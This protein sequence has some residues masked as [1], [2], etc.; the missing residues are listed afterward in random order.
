M[1]QSQCQNPNV[2]SE[3]RTNFDV[4]VRISDTSEVRQED[5]SEHY[6]E[7]VAAMKAGDA[8][9]AARHANRAF[10]L[11]PKPEHAILLARIFTD[12]SLRADALRV[13]NRALDAAA[14]DQQGPRGEAY[15]AMHN[16]A[17]ILL[18]EMKSADRAVEYLRKAVSCADGRDFGHGMRLN[19]ASAE[20][21]RGQW[22]T[23]A[24]QAQMVA[25]QSTGQVGAA[26]QQAAYVVRAVC[27]FRSGAA[28][29]EVVTETRKAV[30]ALPSKESARSTCK[31]LELKLAQEFAGK[32]VR[33]GKARKA[34]LP[35]EPV[36]WYMQ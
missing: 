17:G 24:E 18:S 1:C 14:K 19:L 3:V 31:S 10:K 16:N 5:A 30:Q 9:K 12:K 13:L 22:E 25:A 29:A 27:L 28:H 20:M 36:F 2:Q 32:K 4:K 34:V 26:M 21:Q 33:A 15:C 35:Y 23:C 6:H 8:A 11:D 7:G